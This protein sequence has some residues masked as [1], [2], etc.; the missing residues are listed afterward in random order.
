MAMTL[1]LVV[2]AFLT[3]ILVLS[4]VPF[5]GSPVS[6]HPSA[7]PSTVRSAVSP[8]IVTDPNPYVTGMAAT[9]AIGAPDLVTRWMNHNA[10]A[11]TG[12]VQFA[13]FDSHGDLWVTDYGGKRVVEFLPPFSTGE[14]ASV[15]IGQSSFTGNQ[16]G[17]TAVNLS[18][19]SSDA[20]D[21][22]GDLWVM[23]FSANR[24]LEYKP[25][26][27]TGM[28]ASLVIGQTGFT[29][30][31]AGTTQSTLSGPQDLSFDSQG[32]L[33]VADFGNNRVLE[34]VPPF[35]DGMPASL[36]VGQTSF[37][38]ATFGATATTLN[39]P[40]SA[41]VSPGGD[42]WVSDYGNSRVL[43]YV[44]P[45]ASGM[46]AVIALGQTSLTTTGATGPNS[47]SSPVQALPD[48]AGNIW[49]SDELHNRVV[50]FEA[51]FSDFEAP[52][53]AIGQ[54]SLSGTAPGLT[55]TNLTDPFGVAI[56]P[57]GSL[58]I[59]DGQ[60]NRI[61]EY[62][63]AQFGVTLVPSGLP[64][65]T[66]WSAVV[67]PVDLHGTGSLTGNLINGTYALHVQA[68]PGYRA[69]PAYLPISVSGT[70][71]TIP[72]A[73]TA[74]APNP[75]SSGMPAT[76]VIGQPNFQSTVSA[77]GRGFTNASGLGAD[78]F[79]AAFDAAGDLWVVDSQNERVLEYVPPFTDGMRASVVIGQT[80]FTGFESGTTPQNLSFPDGIAFDA[81]GDLWVADY[82][83]NRVLEYVPP[84]VSGM[85]ASLVLGQSTF[86]ASAG[87]V[88]ATGLDGPSDINFDAAGDLWVADFINAR[89][90]EFVPPFS[91]DEAATL[92]LGQASLTARVAA[93]TA[94]GDVEP[95]AIAF[96][97][98]GDA[99]VPDAFNNRVLE[100]P[101][102]LSMGEAAT[103]VLGQ[104]SFTTA[105][106]TGPD[107]FTHPFGVD[108]VQGN[109]WVADTGDN[110]VLE[111]V[112][113][114]FSNFQTP[115]L[116]LGQG[117]ISTFGASAGAS[118]L[119]LPTDVIADTSG[120]L[121]VVD[122]GN[123]RVLGYI[124]ASYALN[125]TETGLPAGTS[126]SVTVNGTAHPTTASS[127]AV[128][129]YNGTYA[130]SAPSVP[131]Y[132]LTSV[133]SG[134][135]TVNGGATTVAL[136]YGA[137]TYLATFT[138]THLPAGASWSVVINGTSYPSTSPTV[139]IPLANGTY[140]F[141]VPGVPGFSPTVSTGSVTIAS[142]GASE[143]VAFAPYTYAVTFT[144]KGLPSGTPW[145]VT[146]NGAVFTS[147]TTTLVV[148]EPN[149]TFSYTFGS[150]PNY[151]PS[152][153]S[154]NGNVLA[155]PASVSVTYS[156]SSTSPLGTGGLLFWAALAAVIILAVLV[157]VLA[158]RGR[159]GGNAATGTPPAAWAGPGPPPP[160]AGPPGPAP[161]PWS[162]SGP[163]PPGGPPS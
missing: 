48:S 90:L 83:N 47:L 2:V 49:V 130:W 28:A 15:V 45:F 68:P 69:N 37:T 127:V 6:A 96:D 97:A 79:Q 98:Q 118:G 150:V 35:S 30:G 108:V 95:S 38:S 101:A 70:A 17:I 75:F 157:V 33:W 116:A 159:K 53:V 27:A 87:A 8:A 136:S 133:S 10:S 65:G 114:T 141:R 72:I 74:T 42:L 39:L 20:F 55:A 13:K 162:E 131:G 163:P 80:S 12:Y 71:Q 51:P 77:V 32:D 52:S 107:S 105:A 111:F 154:G 24:I 128:P 124:P 120:H 117:N 36:V 58:W 23:D 155:A 132:L 82:L 7:A 25:P 73:F 146:V 60:D 63:P 61:L 84:L 138:E 21:A 139:T 76:V 44:P 56:G 9:L 126:W 109:V 67:G 102:P 88:S 81:H 5:A 129:E 14:K 18:G 43:A 153:G 78:N 19:P 91:N 85:S 106:S 125:Y 160:A 99:W 11:F 113:P 54:S 22:A 57:G 134:T 148:Q 103:V 66:A 94:T 151:G 145:S 143:T 31:T 40:V 62:V 29:T 144:E 152:P 59:T 89:V 112:G 161:A 50:E 64:V 123:I 119:S 92:A 115:S 46:S 100:Y 16:P 93:T 147:A 104:S 1:R 140:S 122:G 4:L 34:F 158:M 149:G 26:F 156:A 86:F 3:A 110:R 142:A 137:V 41:Y 135:A 121:W